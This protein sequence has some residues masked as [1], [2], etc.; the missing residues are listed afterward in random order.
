MSDQERALALLRSNPTREVIE[1]WST[2][3]LFAVC[4][5]LDIQSYDTMDKDQVVSAVFAEVSQDFEGFPSREV[6][7]QSSPHAQGN[8][9]EGTV[10]VSA[11]TPADTVPVQTATQA[12]SNQTLP[13]AGRC[14]LSDLIKLEQ[15][16]AKTLEAEART[17]EAEAESLQLQIQLVQLNGT[18]NNPSNVRQPSSPI[19]DL[20]CVLEFLPSFSEEDPDIYFATFEST[21]EDLSVAEEYWPLL[22]RRAF[23]GKALRVYNSLSPQDAKDYQSIKTEI[24]KAY[25]CIPET[26]RQR[27][28]T[29]RKKTDQSYLE[30]A[31]VKR[32]ALD[33]WLRSREVCDF[34]SMVEVI[35][36]E[37]FLRTISKEVSTFLLD[38]EFTSIEDAAKLAE[39]Y[40]LR[41]SSNRQAGQPPQANT[42]FSDAHQNGKRPDKR[43][44]AGSV[45]GKGNAT[46]MPPNWC[47]V[48]TVHLGTHVPFVIRLVTQ[49]T[50]VT[51][52]S[53]LMKSHDLLRQSVHNLRLQVSQM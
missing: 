14:D 41:H 25:A 17:R 2:Q 44:F 19:S 16:K 31:R 4:D 46:Q 35:L 49:L 3:D 51:D 18:V 7:G 47:Q 34:N 9:D 13:V 5:Y 15:A 23:T 20:K 53:S 26:Y 50:F 6:P 32:E 22:L 10:Q 36:E 43:G 40:S 33:R 8:S 30:F 11:T 12:Q 29:L 45:R 42:K 48:Y 39:S 27:F 37:E 21:V 52:G 1:G 38:R 28:R 24:L